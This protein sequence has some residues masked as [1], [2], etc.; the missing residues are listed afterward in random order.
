MEL[1]AVQVPDPR[2]RHLQVPMEVKSPQIY[3]NMSLES[4]T[5]KTERKSERETDGTRSV[6]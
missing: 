3:K 2:C 6:S 1:A 4:Y 5:Q